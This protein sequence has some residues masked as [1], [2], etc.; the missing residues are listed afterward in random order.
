MREA[1]FDTGGR[2]W[3]PGFMAELLAQVRLRSGT[4]ERTC[5]IPATAARAGTDVTLKN[6]EEPERWW[7]VAWAG[8]ERRLPG[9]INRGWN[10]NI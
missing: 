5:W 9:G 4:A 6:S 1:R 10:N 8:T 2:L 3:Q 7:T